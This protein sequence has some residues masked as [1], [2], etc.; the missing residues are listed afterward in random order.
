MELIVKYLFFVL[1]ICIFTLPASEA[2][3]ATKPMTF[4]IETDPKERFLNSLHSGGKESIYAEGDIAEGTTDKFLTFVRENKIV[5]AKIYLNSAGGLLFEGIN[6]GK[7]IRALQFSTTVGIYSPTY[8]SD[9][10][11][12]SICASACAY[13]FAG[14]ESRF[15]NKYTGRLGLHQFYADINDKLS[16]EDAQRVSGIVVSYLDQMGIDAKAFALSTIADSNGMIWLTPD[17]ALELRFSNNG[18]KNPTAELKMINM[19]PYL[20]VE[21]ERYDGTARVTFLCDSL[22]KKIEMGFGIVLDSDDTSFVHKGWAKRNYFELTGNL[23]GLGKEVFIRP[24]IDRVKAIRHVVWIGR[25]LS[26]SD[27]RA[28]I[29]SNEVGGW[30]DGYGAV[31]YGAKLDIPLIRGK[32]SE[33]G[34]QCFQIK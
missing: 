13:A 24:G 7:T 1:G 28:L 4:Y 31:R 11:R 18:T 29:S 10:S 2:A 32:I 5:R 34:T 8:D 15:L 26:S 3:H 33:F 17:Q 30:I 9:K 19:K 27:L 25:T 22:N 6:L 16:G 20:R 12:K 14:G 23:S 21:Q